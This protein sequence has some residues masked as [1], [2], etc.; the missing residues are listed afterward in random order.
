MNTKSPKKTDCPELFH[1][2]SRPYGLSYTEWTERWWKW[3]FSI[4][5]EDNPIVDE[6]GENCEKGQDG[7][8]WYL[9]GTTGKTFHAKRSCI[10]PSQKSVLFP[11]IVSLF[12]QSEKPSMSRKEL[13]TFTAKDI[14]QTSM[15]DVVVDDFSLRELSRY[16]VQSFFNLDFVIE[17][18]I[19]NIESRS[20]KAAS[21][22]YWVFLKPLG[23]GNHKINFQ[24]IEPNFKTKVSYNITVK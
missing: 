8:V 24:G 3:A 15:L 6:T 1:T 7:P 22:G 5:K 17:D 18:N 9:A 12:F 14:D 10:I 20:D 19:W 11:I 2:N 23:V 13:V 21:D 16:R 4:A